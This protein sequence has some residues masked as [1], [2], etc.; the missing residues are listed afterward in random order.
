MA[1]FLCPERDSYPVDGD[2]IETLGR[3]GELEGMQPPEKVADV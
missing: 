3:E 1:E 2:G